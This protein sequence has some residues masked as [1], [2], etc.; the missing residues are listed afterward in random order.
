[1]S[2]N[3]NLACDRDQGLRHEDSVGLALNETQ[4]CPYSLFHD[5]GNHAMPFRTADYESIVDIGWRMRH[6][7]VVS[8][9]TFGKSIRYS[10]GALPNKVA[11]KLAAKG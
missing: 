6:V 3:D 4:S 11:P 8:F 5:G 7:P 10:V 2:V 9:A 1:V